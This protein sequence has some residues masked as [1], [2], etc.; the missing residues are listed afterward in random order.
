VRGSVTRDEG[1]RH[2]AGKKGE[3]IV[4]VKVVAG[5]EERKPRAVDRIPTAGQDL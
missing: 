3:R 1:D 5:A 2:V 4:Y